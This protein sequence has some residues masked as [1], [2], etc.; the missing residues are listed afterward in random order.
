MGKVITNWSPLQLF[1]SQLLMD[2]GE[3][4]MLGR[5]HDF[6]FKLDIYIITTELFLTVK[7]GESPHL[8]PLNCFPQP[9]FQMLHNE[10]KEKGL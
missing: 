9:F 4:R 1:V 7:D 8:N 5:F 6:L 2:L 3:T 10:G